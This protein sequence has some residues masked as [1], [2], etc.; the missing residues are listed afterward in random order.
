MTASGDLRDHLEKID[1]QIIELLG[2][3]IDAC[4]EAA[5]EEEEGLSGESVVDM[6]AEWEEIADEKGWNVPAMGRIA[7]GISDVCKAQA[8]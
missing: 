7:R 2:E 5:E 1:R 6:V 3:R 4:E 8:E